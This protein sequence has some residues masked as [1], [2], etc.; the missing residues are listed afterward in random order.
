MHLFVFCQ[1]TLTIL[2]DEL[3]AVGVCTPSQLKTKNMAELE[4]TPMAKVGAE[5]KLVLTGCHSLVLVDGET[6]GDPLELAA[7]KVRIPL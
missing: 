6:T 3:V 2:K 7:L 1:S 5:A 4:P